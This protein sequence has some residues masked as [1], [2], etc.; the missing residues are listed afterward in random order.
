MLFGLPVVTTEI[1]AEGFLEASS[2]GVFAA[3]SSDPDTMAAA[4][5]RLL[6][7]PDLRSEYAERSRE[8]ARAR[9]DFDAGVE[10][11]LGDYRALTDCGV[12]PGH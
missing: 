12:S 5:I 8:F 3:V 9:F 6:I 4:V 1:G 7:D 10:S 2:S 11:V